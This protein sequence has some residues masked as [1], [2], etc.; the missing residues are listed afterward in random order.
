MSADCTC[1]CAYCA[2]PFDP[3]GYSRVASLRAAICVLVVISPK[4]V[5]A[6]KIAPVVE[7]VPSLVRAINFVDSRYRKKAVCAV[8]SGYAACDVVSRFSASGTCGCEVV[9]LRNLSVLLCRTGV[10][11]RAAAPEGC[12][13]LTAVVFEAI[14]T[15]AVATDCEALFCRHA[16]RIVG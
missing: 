6:A 9:A 16:G 1:A 12:K 11:Y 5:F 13:R 4:P 8:L 14:K 10:A 15:R 2:Q 3:A 7:E